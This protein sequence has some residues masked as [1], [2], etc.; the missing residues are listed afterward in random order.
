[1]REGFIFDLSSNRVNDNVKILFPKGE[2]IDSTAIISGERIWF[3]I[4]S[5]EAGKIINRAWIIKPDGI[6][7]AEAQAE[8][9]DGSWL[10]ELRGKCAIG[11]FLLAATDN[12][13]VRL[14]ADSG[15]IIKTKEFPD[16]DP[17]V[18]AESR[19][20]PSKDGLYAV[21]EKE[22]KLLKII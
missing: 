6:M 3:F 13:I 22:I 18:S 15:K 4:A 21:D 9:G 12:G 7:E 10:S 17:F 8:R 2:I 11:G 19:L 20:F 1:M 5:V 16:T 14:E